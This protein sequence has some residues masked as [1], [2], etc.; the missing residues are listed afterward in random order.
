MAIELAPTLAELVAQLPPT[1][2]EQVRRYAEAVVEAHEA[3]VRAWD[4]SCG[5]TYLPLPGMGAVNA[6]SP[7]CRARERRE[8]LDRGKAAREAKQDRC[9]ACGRPV[10]LTKVQGWM[11][12]PTHIQA[13]KTA[14]CLSGAY[15]KVRRADG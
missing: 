7:A 14:P 6:C 5:L 8:R 11:M 9:P 15:V 10:K 12:V 2:V 3:G 4:C 13:G 1:A